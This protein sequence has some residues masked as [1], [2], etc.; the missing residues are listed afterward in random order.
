M[1]K[2]KILENGVTLIC[3]TLKN[4]KV[5]T[6][7]VGFKVGSMNEK[8]FKMF[9]ISHAVEHMLFKGTS[10]RTSKEIND[11]IEN[12][13]GL[14]NAETSVNKTVYYINMRMCD[15]EPM[16]EILFDMV[17]NASFTK[18]EWEKEKDVIHQEI[19]MYEDDPQ[20]VVQDNIFKISFED[21]NLA[22]P[23]I[24]YWDSVKNITTEDLKKYVEDNYTSDR[25]IVSA[26]GDITIEELEKLVFKYYKKNSKSKEE[27][28][29]LKQVYGKKIENEKD[30]A[31]TY[32]TMTLADFDRTKKVMYESVVFSEIFSGGMS[33]KLWKRIR[34]ELGL[35]YYIGC[36]YIPCANKA[37][38]G[39]S[40]MCDYDQV[41]V[42]I[43]NIYDLIE[44]MKQGDFSDVEFQKALNSQEYGFMCSKLNKSGCAVN[45]LKAYI[46]FKRVPNE[47]RDLKLIKNVTKENVI[48][49]AKKYFKR[50][51]FN[52][53]IV[54]PKTCPD[55]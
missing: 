44:E 28:F 39:I 29:N 11:L 24:G 36:S 6:I 50:N 46:S 5:G 47:N 1:I 9:G 55:F 16:T 8:E 41:N 34:E 17:Q 26:S 25:M 21:E 45:N 14:A 23:V 22:H 53:A 32:V 40:F 43:D 20:G 12:T 35:V 27:D 7:A 3:E 18:E 10:T 2:T 52:I 42:I 37:L 13:G 15:F 51:K 31:Q 54:K 38:Y 19:K 30:L 49:F 48:N 4:I 33:S